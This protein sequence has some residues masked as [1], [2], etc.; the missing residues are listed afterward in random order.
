[1][2]SFFIRSPIVA[3]VMAIVTVIIGGSRLRF[4]QSPQFQNMH[5]RKSGMQANYPGATRR[6]WS[7]PSLPRSNS[8]CTGVDNMEYCIP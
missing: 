5:R 6:L 8:K 3:I 1:M 4:C 2:A 7:S